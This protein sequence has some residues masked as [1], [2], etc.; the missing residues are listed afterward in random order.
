MD[1]LEQ[2]HEALAR[3][4]TTLS[5]TVARV[6]LNQTHASELNKLRFDSLDTSITGVAGNL[7]SFMARINSIIMGETKL[8]QAVQGEELVADYRKWRAQVDQRL[9]AGEDA[10][11]VT[12]SR[13]KGVVETL[14][15]GRAAVVFGFAVTG[16]M[17]TIASFVAQMTQGVR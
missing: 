8:P 2:N 16:Y 11:L 13:N 9:D 6:E 10:R 14:G 1:R 4:V 15:V 17:L 5:A 7:T 12:T 3:D